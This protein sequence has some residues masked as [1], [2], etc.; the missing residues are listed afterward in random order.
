MKN[1]SIND[2]L[3]DMRT[4][5]SAVLQEMERTEGRISEIYSDDRYSQHYR[6]SEKQR[7]RNELHD[8][9][10]SQRKRLQDLCNEG[11]SYISGDRSALNYKA[12]DPDLLAFLNIAKLD[13]S[14][15]TKLALMNA[16]SPTTLAVL[17]GAAER[18]GYTLHTGKRTAK[19]RIDALD[20][21][22]KHAD[23]LLRD[24]DNE[25]DRSLNLF[26]LNESIDLAEEVFS[27]SEADSF[28]CTAIG[29]FVSEVAHDLASSQQIS[30]E[31]DKQF[32]ESFTGKKTPENK[33]LE[34]VAELLD[35]FG[36]EKKS[37]VL[38]ALKDTNSPE[39]LNGKALS[40]VDVKLSAD[41][42]RK[43]GN[44]KLADEVKHVSD[45]MCAD[46]TVFQDREGAFTKAD[47]NGLHQR[48]AKMIAQA[49]QRSAEKAERAERLK[50]VE[51]TVKEEAEYKNED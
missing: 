7:M 35:S 11:K 39:R 40:A 44:K 18:A 22:Y 49:K 24:L 5:V 15:F 23:I 6:E 45:L 26:D 33:A 27:P 29:D 20:A 51:Q 41:R 37:R 14:D 43:S 21:V 50:K 25:A 19:E 10:F 47:S 12:L 42:I 28:Y 36:A 17:E 8:Y 2:I 31:T 16:G 30:E 3:K 46:G 48:H 4:A 32:V 9:A 34:P 38:Q 13:D 1:N